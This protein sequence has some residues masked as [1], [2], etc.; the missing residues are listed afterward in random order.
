MTQT[1][2]LKLLVRYDRVVEDRICIGPDLDVFRGGVFNTSSIRSG[3]AHS[4]GVGADPPGSHFLWVCCFCDR[5]GR[6]VKPYMPCTTLLHSI[7][8]NKLTA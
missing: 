4:H 8:G 3:L 1:L 2:S 6:P 7:D 5:V